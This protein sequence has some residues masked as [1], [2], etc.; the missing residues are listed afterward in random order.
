VASVLPANF[1]RLGEDCRALEKAGVDRVQW[2]IMDGC[3]VLCA[4]SALFSHPAGPAAA[5]AELRPAAKKGDRDSP[6]PPG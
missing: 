2:D 4:G 3:F 6:P 1:A 5:V